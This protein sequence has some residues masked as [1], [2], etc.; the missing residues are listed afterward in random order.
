[1][2]VEVERKKQMS[3]NNLVLLFFLFFSCHQSEKKIQEKIENETVITEKFSKPDFKINQ[4]ELREENSLTNFYSQNIKLLDHLRYSPV[5]IFTDK[6]KKE[7]LIAYQYEGDVKNSFSCFEVGHLKD[8]P[9]L[10]KEDVVKTKYDNFMT[11]SGLKLGIT[12][13][14]ITNLKGSDFK[15][16]KKPNE[17]IIRYT[18]DNPDDPK[19]KQ[20][21]M[22]P[23]FMEFYL[24]DK[25]VYKII[26]GFEY[27]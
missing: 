14:E 27:P 12:L 17:E 11:E 24:K 18:I 13:E 5:T 25:K 22:P 2:M 20:Y 7:Y 4:L 15:V 3:M 6:E 16:E 26:F 1:M 21:E 10:E 23:Y 19:I 9:K 8:D